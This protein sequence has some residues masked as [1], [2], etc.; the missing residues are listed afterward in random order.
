VA[1][2][3]DQ[4][5][6]VWQALTAATARGDTAAVLAIT[7][8]AQG[9]GLLQDC[10]PGMLLGAHRRCPRSRRAGSDPRDRL[11]RPGLARRRGPRRPRHQPRHQLPNRARAAGDRAGRSGPG[12]GRRW[13]R[14]AGP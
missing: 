6:S 4:F 2:S 7:G 5:E 11:A 3:L 9:L 13:R 12:P 8:P 14:L 1:A 10:G